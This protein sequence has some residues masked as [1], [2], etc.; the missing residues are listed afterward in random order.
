M[1]L[2]PAPVTT[3]GRRGRPVEQEEGRW[4]KYLSLAVEV[5]KA[6][7]TIVEACMQ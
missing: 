5:L 2:L 7:A 1:D 6:I 4:M 3:G